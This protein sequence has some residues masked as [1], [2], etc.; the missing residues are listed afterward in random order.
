MSLTGVVA[1]AHGLAG[2]QPCINVY[3]VTKTAELLR[4][5]P[6]A[7]EGYPVLVRQAGQIQAQDELD[8]HR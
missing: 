2:G 1:T 6:D 3:A 8:G 7:I 5:V 4:Q